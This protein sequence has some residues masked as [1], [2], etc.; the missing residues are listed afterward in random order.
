MR[1]SYEALR[2]AIVTLRR[3]AVREEADGCSTQAHTRQRANTHS[4]ALTL[5]GAVQS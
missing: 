5:D 2:V 3:V 1:K 4:R